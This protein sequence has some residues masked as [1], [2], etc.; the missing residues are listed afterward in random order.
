MNESYLRCKRNLS[1]GGWKSLLISMIVNISGAV[2]HYLDDASVMFC[3]H[4]PSVDSGAEAPPV[5]TVRARSPT[6]RKE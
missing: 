6:Q 1:R 3:A 2:Q 4:R 5:A